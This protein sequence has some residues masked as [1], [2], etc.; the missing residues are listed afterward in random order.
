MSSSK[1]AQPCWKCRSPSYGSGRE[2]EASAIKTKAD[3][4]E[5]P[6]YSYTRHLFLR[7]SSPGCAITQVKMMWVIGGT[8]GPLLGCGCCIPR[9]RRSKNSH[10]TSVADVEIMTSPNAANIKPINRIEFILPVYRRVCWVDTESS[11]MRK[12][13][14]KLRAGAFSEHSRTVISLHPLQT[15]LRA[16]TEAGAYLNGKYYL[17]KNGWMKYWWSHA[18]SL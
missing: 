14:D 3:V 6:R 17:E 10:W 2:F 8:D 11:E 15:S 7:S 4:F 13:S 16:Q 18:V 12:K 9:L 1:S 5:W